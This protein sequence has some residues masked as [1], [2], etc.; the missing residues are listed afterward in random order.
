MGGQIDRPSILWMSRSYSKVFRHSLKKTRYSYSLTAHFFCWDIELKAGF[1]WDLIHFPVTFVVELAQWNCHQSISSLWL[2]PKRTRRHK[3]SFYSMFFVIQ[4]CQRFQLEI[5]QIFWLQAQL[6]SSF[7][8]TDLFPVLLLTLW[9]SSSPVLFVYWA[10][11]VPR[12]E[13]N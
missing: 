5:S 3:S 12:V 11:H 1:L 7:I 13:E 10:V 4:M 8:Q 2:H 9:T 6:V